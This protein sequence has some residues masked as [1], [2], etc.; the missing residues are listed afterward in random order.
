MLADFHQV[1]LGF[2]GEICRAILEDL[3]SSASP[4]YRKECE[5]LLQSR[6]EKLVEVFVASLGGEPAS[7]LSYIEQMTEE[8]ICEGY[9]LNEIQTV[10]TLLE[11]QFWKLAIKHSNI[12][13]LVRNLSVVT[14][15]IGSAKDWLAQ[16]YLA[17]RRKAE[18]NIARLES[19]LQELFKGTESIV[20][21]GEQ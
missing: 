7:F 17:E 5:S 19:R 1:A 16:I 11:Q 4:H 18:A 3:R 13:N 20:D 14:S 9:Y 12:E 6:V 21:S 8:R 15:F 2:Q 10:L